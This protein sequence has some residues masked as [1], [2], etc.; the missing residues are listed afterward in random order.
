MQVKA[1]M[2][3]RAIHADSN[4]LW[5]VVHFLGGGSWLCEIVD[6]PIE[7]RGRKVSSDWAGTQKAFLANEILGSIDR[8]ASLNRVMD[9]N[10][11]FLQEQ[12]EGALLHY[13]NGFGTYVRQVVVLHEGRKKLKPIAMLGPWFEYD[14]PYYRPNGDKAEG[15]YVK[16]IL[17]G[18]LSDRLQV[19]TTYEHPS[20]VKPR[21]VVEVTGQPR[22][23]ID[24]RKLTPHKLE[25]DPLVGDKAEAA[26]LW[27]VVE[28]VQAALKLNFPVQ[29]G[30]D[31]RDPKTPK[32]LLLAAFKLLKYEFKAFI[33]ES[34]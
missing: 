17:E 10:E 3:F 25:L 9:E 11:R 6:E 22:D 7:I 29:S 27:K 16:K 32:R 14:L 13:H 15:Y 30:I 33:P 21:G 1:G 18:E 2:Q 26:R 34:K 19:S 12:P 28:E 23:Q 8:A 20:F 31:E 24:P 5:N 4:A